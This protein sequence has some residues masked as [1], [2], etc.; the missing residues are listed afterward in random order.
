MTEHINSFF[1]QSGF[2]AHTRK[3]FVSVTVILDGHTHTA[4]M[5]PDNARELAQN[6]LQCA[7]A[8]DMDAIVMQFLTERLHQPI[9]AAAAVLNDFR[10]LRD[11]LHDDPKQ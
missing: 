4:Q 1:C 5:P 10:T 7:E 2:G 3:P 9:E 11:T 6:L 8:A